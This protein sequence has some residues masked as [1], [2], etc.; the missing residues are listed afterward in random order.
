MDLR[1]IRVESIRIAP[2]LGVDV[3]PTLPLLDAKFELRSTTEA[4]SRL[5]AMN[6]VAAAS[7]GF[8]KSSTIAWLEQEALTDVLTEEERRFLFEGTGQPSRFHSQVEGMW[9]L[10]W[11]MGFVQELNFD[12]DC[13][14]G[15]AAMLPDLRVN[16]SSAAFREKA[17]ARALE[18]V[19][20]ACDLAY[21]L[22]CAIRQTELN[23]TRPAITLK[24]SVVVERRRA[25]EWLLSK[26]PWDEVDLD[27]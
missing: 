21:C 27:T 4:V 10:A 7:Y 22:H 8:D 9:T 1:R 11:A 18:Q 2:H 24:S 14:K 19:V 12:E 6:G 25:M 16:Q 13:D 23:G 5:L 15:F 20:A 26:E 3:S 17:K